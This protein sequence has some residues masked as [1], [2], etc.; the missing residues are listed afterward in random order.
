MAADLENIEL[1]IIKGLNSLLNPVGYG[2]K[3][4][5]NVIIDDITI[6]MTFTLYHIVGQRVDGEYMIRYDSTWVS[7]EDMLIMYNCVNDNT[8]A[9]RLWLHK[10]DPKFKPLISNLEYLSN[11]VCLEEIAVKLDLLGV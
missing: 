11:S 6:N 3:T 9:S 8:L 4:T 7:L 1:K 5:K 10:N 2:I